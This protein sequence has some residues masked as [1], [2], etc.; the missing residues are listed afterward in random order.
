MVF[1]DTIKNAIKFALKTHEILQKQKRKGKD[2]PYVVHPLVVGMILARAGC[3][4]DVVAA[5]ILHDTIEDCNPKKPVTENLISQK[6]SP[7]IS[8]L[9]MSVTEDKSLEWEVRKQDLIGRILTYDRDS[10]LIKSA[11]VL[12]NTTELIHDVQKKGDAIF[13]RFAKGKKVVLGHYLELIYAL[14]SAN[15]RLPVKSKN[16]FIKELIYTAKELKSL[17]RHK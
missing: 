11:D 17:E 3:K 13:A 7:R 4:D 16:P 9:V 15:N 10:Q 14:R 6:F 12:A 5:G 8:R 1:N 2:I